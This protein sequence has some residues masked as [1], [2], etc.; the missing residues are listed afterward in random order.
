[1]PSFLDFDTF[2]FAYFRK[3]NE[4]ISFSSLCVYYLLIEQKS[5]EKNKI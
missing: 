5:E 2:L 3:T 1:M 4:I